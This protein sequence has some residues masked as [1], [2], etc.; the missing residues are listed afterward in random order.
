MINDIIRRRVW[1]NVPASEEEVD[2]MMDRLVN[3]FQDEYSE[4][5]H[6]VD[7][8]NEELLKYAELSGYDR[9]SVPVM[10]YDDFCVKYMEKV[11]SWLSVTNL[12]DS[13]A[14]EVILYDMIVEHIDRHK[15]VIKSVS[16]A[17]DMSGVFDAP[18]R[19]QFS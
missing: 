1:P 10:T 16:T 18:I 11:R 2:A 7:Q 14:L 3:G 4:W 17:L 9:S 19:M 8:V 6:H 12:L 5:K 15:H 13:D